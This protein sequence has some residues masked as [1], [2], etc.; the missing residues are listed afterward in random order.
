M[1]PK[2]TE[3]SRFPVFV[4]NVSGD[5]FDF[6][7]IIFRTSGY[8]IKFTP[9]AV[10]RKDKPLPNY[11]RAMVESEDISQ[12]LHLLFGHGAKHNTVTAVIDD[13][14]RGYPTG[15]F[16]LLNQIE[17]PFYQN[18]EKK[19]VDTDTLKR[20]FMKSVERVAIMEERHELTFLTEDEREAYRQQYNLF[21][22]EGYQPIDLADIIAL[23]KEEMPELN[24]KVEESVQFWRD[25]EA[26]KQE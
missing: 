14:S 9:G 13:V 2:D 6:D 7:N 1:E 21:E 17:G 25:F 20:C 22:K 5:P 26:R 15:I 12:R 11:L 23:I 19:D 3:V 8:Q 18:V 10:D 16:Y 24:R 4:S